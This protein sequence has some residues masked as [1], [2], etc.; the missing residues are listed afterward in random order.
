MKNR[1]AKSNMIVDAAEQLF[2]SQGFKATSMDQIAREADVAKGT[3]YLYFKSKKE[4]YYAV[5]QRAMECLKGMFDETSVAAKTGLER[6]FSYAKAFLKFQKEH[7]N[8]YDFI[9]NYQGEKYKLSKQGREVKSTYEGSIH[10]FSSVMDSVKEGME[11]GSIKVDMEPE[12]LASLL[13]CEICGVAQFAGLRELF[14]KQ[15]S[16][17]VTADNIRDGFLN[18]TE[19]FIS[20]QK[21]EEVDT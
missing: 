19:F 9:I 5:G 8:Y 12:L 10:L 18:L 13:W 2:F 11:D 1:E 14:F 20:G 16:S 3:L 15:F 21:K 7:P 4:L 17:E 6:L